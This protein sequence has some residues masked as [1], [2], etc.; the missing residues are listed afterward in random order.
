MQ[1]RLIQDKLNE[2]ASNYKTGSR[3]EALKAMI[4]KL[5]EMGVEA[6]TDEEVARVYTSIRKELS[7][8]N[9]EL[10][11]TPRRIQG[12]SGKIT[13]PAYTSLVERRKELRTPWMLM[14]LCSRL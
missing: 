12:I 8:I 13:N 6:E 3:P 2:E 14:S 11:T 4:D 9:A 5:N 7:D 10:E 1:K